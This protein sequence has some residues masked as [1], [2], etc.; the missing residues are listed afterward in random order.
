M[1][2]L[3][4]I[5]LLI[6]PFFILS[7]TN[8]PKQ[9]EHKEIKPLKIAISKA[10]GSDGYLQYVKWVNMLD[11]NAECFDMYFISL[12]SA[13]LLF[14]N[15]DGLVISGGPDV[16]PGRFNKTNDTNRCGTIDAK[17]DTL[18]LALIQEALKRKMPILGVCRGEQ[19]FNVALGGS[20]II[21]IPSDFDTTVSHR[22]SNANKCFHKV[23]IKKASLLEEICQTNSGVVN[24]N[25]HQAVDV[26][27]KDLIVCAKS[28]DGLIEAIEWGNPEGKS[29]FIGVQW[30]PERLD[31]TNSLSWNIGKRFMKE[32]QIYQQ[33]RK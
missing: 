25:H 12:D 14:D 15:C 9:K 21:D 1:K 10:K 3:K 31:S 4:Y 2:T 23:E 28:S 18:E 8:A 22:C 26:L 24:T 19:I 20:L 5:F 6:I 33:S 11:S 32:S 16:F 17:R 7:C 30:H 29:F 13:M 27:G